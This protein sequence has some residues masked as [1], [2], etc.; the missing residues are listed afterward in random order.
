MENNM[1]KSEF[2]LDTLIMITKE[3]PIKSYRYKWKHEIS[4]F[5]IIFRKEGYYDSNLVKDY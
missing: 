1:R 4:Y 2:N 5:G 3:S